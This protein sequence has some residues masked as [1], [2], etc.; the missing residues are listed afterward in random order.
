M[1]FGIIIGITILMLFMYACLVVA[2]DADRR[3]E[4]EFEKW[5]DQDDTEGKSS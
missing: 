1:A 3:H 2:S 4:E 5:R